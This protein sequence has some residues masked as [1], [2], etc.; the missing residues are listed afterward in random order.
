MAALV[1]VGAC[2]GA[3]VVIRRAIVRIA[4]PDALRGRVAAVR[5]LF[6]NATNELGTFESGVAAALLGVIPAIWTGGVI[7]ILVAG[8]TAWRA[9]KLLGLDMHAMDR[10]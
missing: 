8:A 10:G 9:P 7:T 3:S 2:D 5:G 1:F 6:L 4:A